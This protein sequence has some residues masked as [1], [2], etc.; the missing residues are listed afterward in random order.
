MESNE[1]PSTQMGRYSG[2]YH[3]FAKK[4]LSKVANKIAKNP[5]TQGVY[6]IDSDENE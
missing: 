2:L 4:A 6:V 5:R 1:E 3:C